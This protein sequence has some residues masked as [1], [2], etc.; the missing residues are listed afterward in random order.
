M[1]VTKHSESRSRERLGIPKK[2]VAKMAEDALLK[3]KRHSDFSG[4]IKRYLDGVF[5]QYGNANNMRV[6]VQHLFIFAGETL[7]TVWPLP[8]KYRNSKAVLS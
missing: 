3:G 5:L 6:Y 4:S 2:A 7:I 1:R 8:P